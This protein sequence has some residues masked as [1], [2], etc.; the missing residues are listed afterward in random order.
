MNTPIV[1]VG[2][3]VKW[4]YKIVV[5]ESPTVEMFNELGADGWELAGILPMQAGASFFFKRT[6]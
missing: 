3:E 4:E 5:A 1:Y 2:E 6:A